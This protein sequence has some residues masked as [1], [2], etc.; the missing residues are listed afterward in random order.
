MVAAWERARA[1]HEQRATIQ[2]DEAAD[3]NPWLRMTGW[4]RYLDG[5]HPQD[6]RQLVEAPA[7]DAQDRED[8]VE[9]AVRVIWDAMDQLARRSQRTVQRCGAGIRVEAAR[10]EAGQTPYQPLQ[11]Y[12]D[13][14]SVQKHVQPWQQVLAFIARTQA[15]AAQQTG[16]HEDGQ[17]REWL[18]KL[19]AYGMTPRQRHKWQALWQLATP[20]PE[21]PEAQIRGRRAGVR[22]V[23]TFAGAGQIIEDVWSAGRSPSPGTSAG[24]SVVEVE[25]EADTVD[26]EVEAWQMPAIEQACLEF[27]VELLNQRHRTHE[28]ESALVCAMA[29]QGWGPGE[30][31]WRDPSSYPP[32]LSRVIK[33]A[34]FIVVQKALWL[35]P[36]ARDIIRMWVGGHKPGG[37]HPISWPLT[38]A[39]D[40]L[41]DINQ[42]GQDTG[43]TVASPSSA[44]GVGFG[45]KM[46]HDHVQQMVRSFMVRGSHGPMQTLLD[47]RTYGLKVHYNTTAPG[48]VGWMGDDE[49][50]Y[51]DV[52]FTMGAFRGFVHGLVGSTRELLQEILYIS[53]TTTN[54]FPPIPWSALYDYATQGKKGWCFLQDTRTRWPVEG[55]QWL[56]QRLRSEP[57]MQRQFMRHG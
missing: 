30:A 28:Y 26:A 24:A 17:Q 19:P 15:A 9:Q 16:Q 13:E 20:A 22:V 41:V 43:S 38:S 54:Q 10:T 4:A 49:L 55:K 23:H 48:H 11:A 14:A 1:Q 34:R 47:W 33:V 18:G 35:D 27:C 12:M 51:K 46:F 32:I 6:L 8:R 25:E 37:N 21:T 42:Q 52:H 45:G 44:S 3:A 31:R 53:T 29:V 39:D 5:V 50:L 57:A 56:I 7:E 2:A 40:E 36:H